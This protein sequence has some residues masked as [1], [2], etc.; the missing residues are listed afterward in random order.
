MYL[1]CYVKDQADP[2]TQWRIALP[3]SM[4]LPTIAWFHEVMGHPGQTR[5]NETLIQRYYHPQLRYRIERFKCDY[6]KRNKLVGKGYGLLPMRELKIEPLYIH[7]K[8]IFNI[9][10]WIMQLSNIQ[11]LSSTIG[12]HDP[13]TLVWC[14]VCSSKP[15]HVTTYW[16]CQFE[17]FS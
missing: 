10:L 13:C 1:S 7:Q 11:N 3:Q 14:N 17:K 9:Y 4:V 15:Y 16:H 8:T 6:C 12:I 5:L 2:N